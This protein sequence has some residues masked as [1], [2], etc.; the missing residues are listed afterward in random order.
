MVK[1][2]RRMTNITIFTLALVFYLIMWRAFSIVLFT[3]WQLKW[4]HIAEDSAKRDREDAFIL[5]IFWPA[6]AIAII[7]DPHW[8]NVFSYIQKK[9]REENAQG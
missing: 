2:E 7:I 9:R 3:F 4:P 8:R 1:G 5:A 6:V